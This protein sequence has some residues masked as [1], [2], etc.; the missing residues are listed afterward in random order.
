MAYS[1]F[2]NKRRETEWFPT[3]D[4]AIFEAISK[5]YVWT[6]NF[7]WDHPAL[8]EDAEI[9]NSGREEITGKI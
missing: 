2:V 4:Q 1:V 7:D 6:S 5:G 9:V 3:R 8:Q